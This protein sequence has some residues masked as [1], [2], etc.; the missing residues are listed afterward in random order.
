MYYLVVDPDSN[1]L[2]AY[3]R[4]ATDK[5]SKLDAE[6]LQFAIC[7]DCEITFDRKAAF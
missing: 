3:Q 1:M 2:I 7:D 6:S 4:D 5:F